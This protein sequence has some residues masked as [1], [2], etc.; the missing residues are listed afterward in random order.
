MKRRHRSSLLPEQSVYRDDG[1][2]HHP[3]CL[4]CPFPRCVHDDPV[5]FAALLRNDAG[6]AA[7]VRRL[8]GEGA[9]PPRIAAEMGVSERQVFRLAKKPAYGSGGVLP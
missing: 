1:C 7:E 4:T 3:A 6:Q 2:V 9:S 5:A 8:R